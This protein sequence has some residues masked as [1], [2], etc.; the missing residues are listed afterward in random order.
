MLLANPCCRCG[1]NCTY[2]GDTFDADSI[3]SGA[4]NDVAGTWAISAGEL[5]TASTTAVIVWDT[6]LDDSYQHVRAELTFGAVA[7][8]ARAVVDYVDSSNY[9][10]GEVNVEA[11]QINIRV[12]RVVGGT[13][14]TMATDS[15]TATYTPG[16]LIVL[17]V[18]R[19]PTGLSA[20]AFIGS[21]LSVGATHTALG[22]LK[23]GLATGTNASGTNFQQVTISRHRNGPDYVLCSSCTAKC[24]VCDSAHPLPSSY[25]VDFSPGGMTDGICDCSGF[26]SVIVVDAVPVSGF[27]PSCGGTWTDPRRWPWACDLPFPAASYPTPGGV[28][29]ALTDWFKA[30]LGEEYAPGFFG[31]AYVF[32]TCTMKYITDGYYLEVTVGGAQGV[33]DPGCIS[34]SKTLA[35]YKSARL[36]T[37]AATV[38][39]DEIFPVTLS[40][41]SED[42]DETYTSPSRTYVY[43]N[44]ALPATITVDV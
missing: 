35:T 24:G 3:T 37:V 39:C 10:Y 36:A 1:V 40:K 17:S 22:G 43:C 11:T 5:S 19:T 38:L 15:V 33:L 14:T 13:H 12:V 44:G 16:A 42:Y 25:L 6:N 8:K 7:S 4:W 9:C 18:C 28:W 32:V 27:T 20:N 29:P 26:D 23:A 21:L 2:Y 31:T 41:V 34:G 30:A